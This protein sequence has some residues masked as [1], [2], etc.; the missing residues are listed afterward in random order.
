[1]IPFMS[2]YRLSN[3]GICERKEHR[4]YSVL[5]RRT[6]K[7]NRSG[8]DSKENRVEICEGLMTGPEKEMVTT[9]SFNKG[10]KIAAHQKQISQCSL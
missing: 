8:Q 1:M 5:M 6:K 2:R 9:L 10:A 4:I 7:N 3:S